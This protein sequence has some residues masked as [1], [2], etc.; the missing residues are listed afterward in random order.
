MSILVQGL[1][2]GAIYGLLAIGLVLV[3]KATRVINFAQGEFGTIGAYLAWF[4]IM[5]AR[6]P[7]GVGLLISAALVGG[8]GYMW[9]RFVIRR[10]LDGPKLTMAVATLG[11]MILLGFIG[12]RFGPRI[13]RQPFAGRGP[14]LFGTLIP[15]ARLL[16]IAM[17]IVVGGGLYLFM[18][19]TTF[20]LGLL[21]AAQDPIA[22][23]L[24][25]IRL[26]HLSAFTWI[27]A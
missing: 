3:F 8:I 19:R 13:L 12:I 15:P 2:L 26:R 6:L 14:E 16:A 1:A 18:K 10:M 22:V 7:W 20:G 5:R 21:A 23:R 24:M 25:G 11:L 4:L 9:E 27:V 17:A